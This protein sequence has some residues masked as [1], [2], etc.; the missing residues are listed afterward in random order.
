MEKKKNKSSSF[1]ARGLRLGGTRIGGGGV[2]VA[3]FLTILPRAVERQSEVEIRGF[4]G[5]LKNG[6]ATYPVTID[7]TGLKFGTRTVPIRRRH[8]YGQSGIRRWRL[9][10]EGLG[11]PG[12]Y[13]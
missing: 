3:V 5:R 12:H 2:M 7:F 13:L 8:L 6:K 9:T 11:L 4:L 10:S 1:M